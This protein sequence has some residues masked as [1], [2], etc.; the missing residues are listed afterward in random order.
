[1][2]KIFSLFL[3]LFFALFLASCGTKER[4]DIVSTCYVGYDFSKAVAKDKLSSGMLL[5][6]GEELHDYSP[7]VGDIEKVLNSKVFIYIGGESDVEF[8]EH[9]ILPELDKSK[10]VVINMMDIIKNGGNTYEEEDPESYVDDDNHDHDHDHEEDEEYDEHIWNSITNAKLIVKAIS[11]A[12]V[13]I[14][15]NN[16]DYYIQN[17]NNYIEKLNEIDNNIKG[18]ISSANKD[19]IIFA[20]RFPLLYF[21]KE[22]NLNYD[23]AFKGCETSKEANPKTIENLTKK[24]LDNNINVIFVIELSE[25]NIASVIEQNVK[26]EGKNVSIKTF[27]TMHNVSKDDYKKGVTYIDYMNMNIESLKEALK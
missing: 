12:L 20:D 8:V 4:V 6:P 22:Y 23:A 11:D 3:S 16:K 5:Q 10:T 21:V 24:V 18:V 9:D 19:L 7:T 25:A 2:K 13:S 26:K 14:D 27:Y 17:T 1:M 15:V